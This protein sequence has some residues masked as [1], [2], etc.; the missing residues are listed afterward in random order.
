[1]HTVSDTP[2]NDTSFTRSPDPHAIRDRRHYQAPAAT[3]VGDMLTAIHSAVINYKL[4]CKSSAAGGLNINCRVH[5]PVCGMLLLLLVGWL[6]NGDD[7]YRAASSRLRCPSAGV[8]LGVVLAAVASDSGDV[9]RKLWFDGDMVD[10]RERPTDDLLQH[11]TIITRTN[12][13]H[14]G[15]IWG[16]GTAKQTDPNY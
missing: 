3:Q 7:R 11:Y 1:M 4:H 15:G 2:S 10:R 6:D 9:R 12:Y 8:F 14:L 16:R 5:E 13:G